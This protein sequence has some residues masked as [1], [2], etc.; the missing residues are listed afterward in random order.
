MS[1]IESVLDEMRVDRTRRLTHAEAGELAAYTSGAGHRDWWMPGRD[2]KPQRESMADVMARYNTVDHPEYPVSVR[3]PAKLPLK[4]TDEVA[5]YGSWA[6]YEAG[7]DVAYVPRGQP[8]TLDGVTVVLCAAKPWAGKRPVIASKPVSGGSKK[9]ILLALIS[10]PGGATFDEMQ[11]VTGWKE[12]RGTASVLARG[13]GM[14]WGK[15][16]GSN[17]PR[18]AAT[19]K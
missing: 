11:A 8:Q 10:R 18:W 17:P 12:M 14:A 4:G 9:E 5:R 1:S 3:V 19:V 2:W 15:V 7:R 13:A 16:A 6:E